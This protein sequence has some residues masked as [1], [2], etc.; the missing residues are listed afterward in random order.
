VELLHLFGRAALEAEGGAVGDGGGFAVDRLGD[1]E[2]A[3][4]VAVKQALVTVPEV[5]S[6]GAPAPRKPSSAS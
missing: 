1:A 2:G 6:N 5:F 4:L 3:A